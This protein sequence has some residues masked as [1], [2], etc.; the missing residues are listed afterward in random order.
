MESFMQRERDRGKSNYMEI[1]TITYVQRIKFMIFFL[2]CDPKCPRVEFS[3]KD[4]FPLSHADIYVLEKNE[5]FKA[6]KTG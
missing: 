6:G 3:C 2:R 4:L 1:V 5:K